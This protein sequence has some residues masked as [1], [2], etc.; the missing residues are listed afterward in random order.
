LEQS[1]TWESCP[2]VESVF[3]LIEKRVLLQLFEGALAEGR[4]RFFNYQAEACKKPISLCES[5]EGRYSWTTE[6]MLHQRSKSF[7]Q[8]RM[9]LWTVKLIPRTISLIVLGLVLISKR[10]LAFLTLEHYLVKFDSVFLINSLE[11]ERGRSAV[12]TFRL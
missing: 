10:I 6:K 5:C 1:V 4:H 9:A 12:R 2:G 11:R 8:F 3:A 7:L